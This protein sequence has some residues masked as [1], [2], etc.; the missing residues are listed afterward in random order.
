MPE[1]ERLVLSKYMRILVDGRQRCQELEPPI[2]QG[3]APER[4][5]ST[6][7]EVVEFH[8]L[9]LRFLLYTSY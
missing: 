1:W 7:P 8:R 3:A 2:A 5:F 9:G 4:F 6:F